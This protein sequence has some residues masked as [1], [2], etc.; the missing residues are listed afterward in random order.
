[1]KYKSAL[2][3]LMLAAMLAAS[4]SSFGQ[5]S[6]YTPGTVWQFAYIKTEPGQFENY[7]DWLAGTF[8]KINEFSKKDGSEVSYH[9]LQVNDAREGEPDL[10]LV[11]EYKDY[12]TNAQRLALQKR[13]E[14]MLALDAHKGDT[15]S[16]GR[17]SMRKL[18]GGMELQELI[19]K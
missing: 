13:I 16:G 5:E 8:K 2:S 11:T 17:K 3:A 12:M 6:S 14:S 18:A 9:V 19:L 10:I 15:E 7:M 4:G 1:M